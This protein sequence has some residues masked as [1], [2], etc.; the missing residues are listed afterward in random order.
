M[1]DRPGSALIVGDSGQDGTLLRHSLENRGYR[2]FGVSRNG[3]VSND[4]AVN[5]AGDPIDISDFD[6]V[7]HLIE[8][9]RPDEVYYLAAYHGS[10]ESMHSNNDPHEYEKYARVH[11]NGLLNFL[12]AICKLASG[13]RL[14]Y[15]ASSLVFDGS[16]GPVQNEKKRRFLRS[17]FMA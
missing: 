13:S 5:L 11:V 6:C 15:A 9:T 17:G 8:H 1:N 7:M 10:S 4:P 2:I 16:N 12:S 14:F 3:I